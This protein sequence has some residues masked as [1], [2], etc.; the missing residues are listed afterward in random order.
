MNFIKTYYKNGE[1]TG[2]EIPSPKD[3]SIWKDPFTG[4]ENY[5]KNNCWH[6]ICCESLE[7]QD[8]IW[9]THELI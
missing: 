2:R 8:L 6:P 1:P 5:S 3:N 9:K 4:L 7:E